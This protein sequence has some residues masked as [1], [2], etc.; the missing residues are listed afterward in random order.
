MIITN[1]NQLTIKELL[2]LSNILSIS[3]L[4]QDGKVIS[5]LR[6]DVKEERSIFNERN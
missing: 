5:V 4:I 2:E 6:E 3:Y 1:F